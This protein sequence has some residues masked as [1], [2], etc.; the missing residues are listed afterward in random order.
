MSQIPSP[1]SHRDIWSLSSLPSRGQLI[2]SHAAAPARARSP[3]H[4]PPRAARA[5]QNP[6]RRPPFPDGI[7]RRPVAPV[8]TQLSLVTAVASQP[9]SH[10]PPQRRTP[11]V[12]DYPL[13]RSRSRP[14]TRK[15]IEIGSCCYP[16]STT[17]TSFSPPATAPTQAASAHARAAKRERSPS[18][19]RT[20]TPSRSDRRSAPLPANSTPPHQQ[21]SAAQPASAR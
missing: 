15:P 1:R 11:T 12:R 9:G 14:S 3:D 6:A 20:A 2:L 7:N 4:P 21:G 10:P 18:P 13:A 16:T 17:P 19:P 8:S 5:K